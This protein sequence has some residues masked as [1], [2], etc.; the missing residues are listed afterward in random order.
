MESLAYE[1]TGC[2]FARSCPGQGQPIDTMVELDVVKDEEKVLRKINL[3]F[4]ADLT[5][6]GL[7]LG[8]RCQARSTS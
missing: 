1:R 3:K 4:G 5:A 2:T 7:G 6:G 8:S